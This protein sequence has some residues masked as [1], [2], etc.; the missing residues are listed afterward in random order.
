MRDESVNEVAVS[1]CSEPVK[2]GSLTGIA[3]KTHFIVPSI[4]EKFNTCGRPS[5]KRCLE[6]MIIEPQSK[7]K[8][9]N[10]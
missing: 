5:L 8:S 7:S 1:Q 9:G 6:I 4:F 2:N 10:P 3:K